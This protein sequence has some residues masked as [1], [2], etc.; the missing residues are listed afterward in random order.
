MQAHFFFFIC[1][2]HQGRVRSS[3]Y[4][5][6]PRLLL[7]VPSF[8]SSCFVRCRLLHFHHN[9]RRAW[10]RTRA[11]ARARIM[12]PLPITRPSN[13]RLHRRL[14][15]ERHRWH[16]RNGTLNIPVGRHW[17]FF[18]CPT[19]CFTL[20]VLAGGCFEKYLVQVQVGCPDQQS[21]Q[22]LIVLLLLVVPRWRWV[23]GRYRLPL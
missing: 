10:T 8:A 2:I 11:R 17:M 5:S 16:S 23:L 21:Y 3:L 19:R 13:N 20:D 1:P 4:P 6:E 22:R 12:F 9:R 14:L 18:L 7:S 15:R